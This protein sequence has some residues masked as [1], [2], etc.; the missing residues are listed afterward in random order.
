MTVG[1]QRPQA[2]NEIRRTHA[3]TLCSAAAEKGAH[4]RG[5]CGS[6]EIAPRPLHDP[7]STC[8]GARRYSRALAP[9]L[10]PRTMKPRTVGWTGTFVAM[11]I[12]LFVVVQYFTGYDAIGAAARF[13]WNGVAVVV[14]GVMRALGGLAGAMARSVGLRRLE[15]FATMMTGVGLGYAGSVVLSDARLARA[16]GW[17]GRLRVAV[18]RARNGWLHLH[19]AWKLLL[20]AGLIASQ[21]YLHFLLILFP[22]AF[23]VPLVRRTWYLTADS[24]FGR[25]YR[26]AFG[27]LHRYTIALL[28][29]LPGMRQ[30]I[31]GIRLA[32]IRYLC[33]WR[34]WRYDPRY[35][36]PGSRRRA[37]SL[38]EPVR[39]W[40]RGELDRYIGR[41]LLAGP[42]TASHA[43]APPE[44]APVV[45]KT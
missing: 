11:V 5:P 4:A 12:V 9:T 23:L 40:R 38:I 31:A 36:R 10:V 26:R 43:L 19:L 42:A 1:A 20:V 16:H 33:A 39:L 34:L 24:L 3:F 2:F 8:V 14:N 15:R 21:V 44:K 29:S 18:T 32:R 41:P 37:V 25:W 13:V 6:I 28:R 30:L 17:R 7:V 45:A 22:I 27:H 35:R